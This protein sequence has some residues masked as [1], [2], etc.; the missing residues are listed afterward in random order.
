M[1]SGHHSLVGWLLVHYITTRAM[2]IIAT[3]SSIS[4]PYYFPKIHST[5]S[6]VSQSK[7]SD[8]DFDVY[9][10]EVTLIDKCFVGLKLE[11][12]T[13]GSMKK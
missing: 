6:L 12:F 11:W 2:M 1:G 8:I 7:I 10:S 3:H 9:F 4:D 5:T 13:L